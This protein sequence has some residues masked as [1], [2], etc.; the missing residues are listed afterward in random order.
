M[1]PLN[2]ACSH[3]AY[4]CGVMN[5]R[6]K[7]KKREDELIMNGIKQAAVARDVE[8]ERCAKI[9]DAAASAHDDAIEA[10]SDDSW[11]CAMNEIRESVRE[12][13]KAA[14]SHWRNIAEKIRSGL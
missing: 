6:S 13:W 1:T 2:D 9:A 7:S 12:E 14:E 4:T 5:E 10:I 8:R 11:Q 3:N